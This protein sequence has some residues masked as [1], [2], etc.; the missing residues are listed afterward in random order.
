MTPKI[1]E[2]SLM[3]YLTYYQKTIKDKESVDEC[4]NRTLYLTISTKE[5]N[6]LN[7]LNANKS[8]EEIAQFIEKEEG[9]AVKVD[10]IRRRAKRSIEN[11]KKHFE[12]CLG[13][14]EKKDK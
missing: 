6:V 4:W 11:F 14:K 3:R 1:A 7:G 12:Q 5:F 8:F 13:I 9:K 10:S 2:Y